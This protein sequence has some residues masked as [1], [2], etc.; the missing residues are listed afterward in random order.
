MSF[1]DSIECIKKAERVLKS[2]GQ[3]VVYDKF[4]PKDR[5]VTSG[6]KIANVLTNFVFSDITRSFE[7]IILNSGLTI[8]SDNDADF[9]GN[10]RLIKMTK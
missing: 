6:R 7:S 1:P 2:G 10:F 4:V 5:K 8:L 3:I 9:N